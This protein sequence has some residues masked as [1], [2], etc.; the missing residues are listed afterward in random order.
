VFP[1]RPTSTTDRVAPALAVAASTPYRFE[2]SDTRRVI[3]VLAVTDPSRA[4]ARDRHTDN[5]SKT[6]TTKVVRENLSSR[7]ARVP[8]SATPGTTAW[9]SPQ[10]EPHGIVTGTLDGRSRPAERSERRGCA[11]QREGNGRT[12]ASATLLAAKAAV[13]SDETALASAKDQLAS[14][15]ELS[16]PSSSSSTV[17]AA[18]HALSHDTTTTTTP[19]SAPSPRPAR[20]MRRR[21]P[22]LNSWVPSTRRCETTYYFE[23]GTSRTTARPRRRSTLVQGRTTSHQHVLSGLLSGQTYHYA[24][25]DQLTRYSY[26]KTLRSPPTRALGDDGHRDDGLG[27]LGDLR[28]HS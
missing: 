18:A 20:P 3:V 26:A 21:V 5:S 14:D 9:C 8:P 4:P 28:R 7:R 12:R 24:R 11:R 25:R 19:A 17:T 27:D 23:Y 2:P 1:L 10:D 6:S 15:E 22:H 13:S 16:C